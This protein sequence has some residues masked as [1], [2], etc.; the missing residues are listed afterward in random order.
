VSAWVVIGATLDQGAHVNLM[1]LSERLA[2]DTGNPDLTIT[3]G[4]RIKKAPPAMITT[5]VTSSI[6]KWVCFDFFLA[7]LH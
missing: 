1:T 3:P 4:L 6:A 2:K 7:P 5:L